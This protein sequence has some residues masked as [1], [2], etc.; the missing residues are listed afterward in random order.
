MVIPS[1]FPPPL[2]S[3]GR[4]KDASN[5]KKAN[6]AQEGVRAIA[7]HVLPAN[8]LR[9]RAKASVRCVQSEASPSQYFI[10]LCKHVIMLFLKKF[11]DNAQNTSFSARYLEDASSAESLH[12][13]V[14]D[15]QSC[16]FPL[17]ASLDR[18]VCI[19]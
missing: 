11:V 10:L 5:A 14:S 7:R 6:L 12:D 3:P 16:S 17:L 13:S 2:P 8:I 1:T 18:T 15:C 9:K 4:D 19:S